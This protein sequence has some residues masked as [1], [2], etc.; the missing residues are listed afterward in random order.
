MITHFSVENFKALSKCSLTN[1]K[2]INLLGGKNNTGKSTMMEA[3][4][5]FHDRQN[6][7]SLLRLYRWRGELLVELNRFD[8]FAPIFHGYNTENEIIMK[9]GEGADLETMKIKMGKEDQKTVHVNPNQK[10]TSLETHTKSIADDRLEM[11][12]EFSGPK[13]SKFSKQVITHS[14][15]GAEDMEVHV[16]KSAQINTAI[17]LTSRTPINSNENAIRYGELTKKNKESKILECLK[18]IEPRLKSITVIQQVNN[19]AVLY[20]DI[21]LDVK[22]P[23]HF[24]G[25]GITRVLSILLAIYSN[26]NGIVFIDEIEN[27][28]HYSVMEQVWEMLDMASEDCN[29]QLFI[30]THSYE[31]LGA[32]V[33]SNIKQND[34]N[35]IRLERKED[36]IISK[37]YDFETL[38]VAIEQGWE[39]R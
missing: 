24:M 26:P 1:L 8:V 9:V 29:C 22:V 4:F 21:G 34:M 16:N 7:D 23:I 38:N 27:G 32:L 36:V 31:C 12:V 39:V 30:T 17:F 13:K 3:L 6:P 35:Y 2:R 10:T 5:F 18:V 28:I 19:Q 14:I 25:D 20:G 11:T 33:S 15:K 37:E